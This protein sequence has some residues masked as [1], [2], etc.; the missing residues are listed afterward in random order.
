MSIY[1]EPYTIKSVLDDCRTSYS[2]PG[3]VYGVDLEALGRRL[4]AIP[5]HKVRRQKIMFNLFYEEVIVTADK[6]FGVSF[7]SLL[8]TLAHYKIINDSKSLRL[9]EFLRRRWRMQKV[10]DQVKRNTVKGF[11]LTL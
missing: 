1:E 8:L 2:A 5:I 11:F 3:A 9:E 6:D 4:S 10:E 7:T